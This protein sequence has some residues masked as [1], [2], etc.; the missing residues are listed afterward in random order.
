MYSRDVD[1]PVAL[2]PSPIKHVCTLYN[3]AYSKN[4]KSVLVCEHMLEEVA[5]GRCVSDAIWFSAIANHP[6][7]P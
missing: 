2:A 5:L 4:D 7:P 3:Q 1:I 6:T